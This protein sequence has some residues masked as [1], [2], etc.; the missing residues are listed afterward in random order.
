MEGADNST[1]NGNGNGIIPEGS[2]GKPVLK[3]EVILTDKDNV[4]LLLPGPPV[5]PFDKALVVGLLARA[6]AQMDRVALQDPLKVT[7]A[8]VGAA[9]EL[10]ELLKARARKGKP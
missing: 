6:V 10:E 1:A 4:V 2:A 9:Q 7:E 8:P 5:T 3:L